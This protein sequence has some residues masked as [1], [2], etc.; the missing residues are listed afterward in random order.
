MVAYSDGSKQE[1]GT[2]GAGAYIMQSEGPEISLVLPLGTEAEV[3]DAELEGALMAT[4][5]CTTLVQHKREK[6]KSIYIFL[7]NQAAIERMGH[8]AP[9]P[10]QAI[11]LAM[12]KLADK[13]YEMEVDLVVSWVPGHSG[14]PGNEISDEL[15]NKATQKQQPQHTTTTLTYLKRHVKAQQLLDW[16]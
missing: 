14:V 2:T 5:K 7:D 10:G 15:A 11:A 4:R 9:G 12:S 8:T 1:D 6:P 16:K 3:Y 13:L